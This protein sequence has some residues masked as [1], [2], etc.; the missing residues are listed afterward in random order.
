MQANFYKERLKNY[1]I[2]FL[3]LLHPFPAIIRM[4]YLLIMLI[5]KKKCM[6]MLD[7]YWDS[8]GQRSIVNFGMIVETIY[9]LRRPRDFLIFF[10][11]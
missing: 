8:L 6:I 10:L 5:L 11:L 1:T 9:F 2:Y 4:I 3:F 7:L